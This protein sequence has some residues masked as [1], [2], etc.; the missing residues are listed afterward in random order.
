ML[1][2]ETCSGVGAYFSFYLGSPRFFRNLTYTSWQAITNHHEANISM[3]SL[4]R[5]PKCTY[6]KMLWSTKSNCVVEWSIS[7]LLIQWRVL[8]DPFFFFLLLNHIYPSLSFCQVGRCTH[9]LPMRITFPQN[10]S[11]DSFDA[12]TLVRDI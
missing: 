2:P 4:S 1:V 11:I 9:D 12:L 8:E 5:L 7:H 3:K 6:I 10:R